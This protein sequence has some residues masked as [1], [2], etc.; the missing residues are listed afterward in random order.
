MKHKIRLV[1]KNFKGSIQGW[2]IFKALEK[3]KELTFLKNLDLK[4]KKQQQQQNNP[5][6]TTNRNHN[7]PRYFQAFTWKLESILV[8]SMCH[9]WNC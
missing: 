8:S 2:N 4:K 3:W 7:P 9:I 6:Q 5:T 1:Q